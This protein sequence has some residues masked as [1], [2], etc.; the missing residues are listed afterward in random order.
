[1]SRISVFALPL[2]FSMSCAQSPQISQASKEQANQSAKECGLSHWTYSRGRE[3]GIAVFDGP[4]LTDADRV[5]EFT[6]LKSTSQKSD[7]KVAWQKAKDIKHCLLTSLAK[8]GSTAIIF[9]SI[10]LDPKVENNAQTH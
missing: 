4:Q 6:V 5:I 10:E 7:F 9:E 1:V 2:F 8:Q 3:S